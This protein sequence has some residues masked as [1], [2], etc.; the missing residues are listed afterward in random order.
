MLFRSEGKIRAQV[1]EEKKKAQAEA[2]MRRAARRAMLDA[3]RNDAP[4]A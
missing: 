1:E 2:E 4:Q 3:A